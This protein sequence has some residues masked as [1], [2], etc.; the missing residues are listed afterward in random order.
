MNTSPRAFLLEDA[1]SDRVLLGELLSR[2]QIVVAGASSHLAEALEMLAVDDHAYDVLVIDLHLPDSQGLATLA[3]VV[4]QQ[5]SI[6]VLVVTGDEASAARAVLAGA[7]DVVLKDL[8]RADLGPAITK[9]I[10]RASRPGALLRRMGE[11]GFANADAPLAVV[12]SG[13]RGVLSNARLLGL[14]APAVRGTDRLEAMFHEDDRAEVSETVAGVRET[15]DGTAW[16]QA[17]LL[18]IDGPILHD[19]VVRQIQVSG[20]C[21]ITL[22]REE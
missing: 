18:T 2:E 6:P 22:T 13:G 11:A 12:G 9:I 20:M 4:E 21:S 19:V 16:T 17:K 7:E 15:L 8:A 1:P 5:P 14:L 10:Q 3:A